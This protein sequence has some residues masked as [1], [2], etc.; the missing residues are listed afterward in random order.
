[1]S[2]P[3]AFPATRAAANERY[4]GPFVIEAGDVLAFHR[5]VECEETWTLLEGGP[6]EVHLIHADGFHEIRLLARGPG[7]RSGSTTIEA[8]SLRAARLAPGAARAALGRSNARG[9]RP[10]CIE[11]PAAAEILKRHPLH[12][13]IVLALT[14]G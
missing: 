1:M 3:G 8:G 13:V 4:R 14:A 12:R 6:L 10:E 7:E 5:I 11:V 9:Q 2:A